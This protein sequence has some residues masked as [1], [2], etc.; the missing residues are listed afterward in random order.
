MLLL[1]FALAGE[2][3]QPDV[4][5]S[6]GGMPAYYLYDSEQ[7]AR[8]KLSKQYPAK[9]KKA[10]KAPQVAEQA[11]SSAALSSLSSQLD[12]PTNEAPARPSIDPKLQAFLAEQEIRAAQAIAEA[13]EEQEL[14]MCL[15]LI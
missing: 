1:L 10:K 2:T 5:G 7:E 11:A 13:Q 15:M 12:R 8:E 3:E 14:A 9:K 4:K 6:G